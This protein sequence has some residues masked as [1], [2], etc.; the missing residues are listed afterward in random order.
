MNLSKR[1]AVEDLMPLK[2]FS[3]LQVR[4]RRIYRMLGALLMPEAK[5]QNLSKLT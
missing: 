2:V 3:Y 4:N 5:K 1:K